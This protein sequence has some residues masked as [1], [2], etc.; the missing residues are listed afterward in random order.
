M[1]VNSG[2][3][4]SCMRSNSVW[5]SGPKRNSLPSPRSCGNSNSAIKPTS[6]GY[7][8]VSVSWN[9]FS[10]SIASNRVAGAFA[11]ALDVELGEPPIGGAIPEAEAR[12]LR[13]RLVAFGR[14]AVLEVEFALAVFD[15]GDEDIVGGAC[16]C[17]GAASAEASAAS[18]SVFQ[19]AAPW[20]AGGGPPLTHFMPTPMATSTS[21]VED[22]LHAG[23]A[24]VVADE[25]VQHRADDRG[26]RQ[27][28]RRCPTAASR[29]SAAGRPGSGSAP[30]A[31]PC[32]RRG[33]APARRSP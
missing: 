9:L 29:G 21:D 17:A 8:P 4:L 23:R 20:R 27:Q 30:P 12:G 1:L 2:L 5:N 33:T 10:H 18:G 15:G 31:T 28:R 24:G 11:L 16:E 32:R 19:E 13:G 14:R 26:L 7:L 6:T 22:D 3:A 25:A